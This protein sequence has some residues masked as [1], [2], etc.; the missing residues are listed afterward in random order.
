[1]K[2]TTKFTVRYRRKR[3][4]RTNYKKRLELLK[5]KTERLVVRRTNTQIIMQITQYEENGDKILLTT[6]SKELSKKGWKHSYKNTPAA[7]LTGMLTAQK[8]KAKGITKVIVDLGLQ[9]PIKGSKVF[10]AVKGAI[11]AGLEIKAN[12]EIFPSDER[13]K[14]EHIS[15]YLDNHKTIT[16]D[17]EKIKKELTE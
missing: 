17:F 10:A 2:S 13:I 14:G 12:A 1:M 11:D 6:Q 16:Q 5:G 3:E 9:T 7:Y 4:G 15:N 8:A